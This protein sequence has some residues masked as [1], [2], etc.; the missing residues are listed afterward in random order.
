MLPMVQAKYRGRVCGAPSWAQSGNGNWQVALPFEV[1]Q[2]EHA[3]ETITWIG[4]MHDTADKNG[5][6]GHERVIQSL[7]YAG[8]QGDD[9]SELAELDDGQA[10]QIFT[11]EVELACAPDTYDGKT[12]VKVQ[13]V[14]KVGAGRFAF[15]EA[16]TKNDLKSFAAQMKATVRSAR[17]AV[18]AKKPNGTTPTPAPAAKVSEDDIPF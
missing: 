10:I 13:W 18:I 11:E 9:I 6:T 14:N 7:Q 8:W 17:G 16:A 4:V 5:T 12:R 3:G 15:K 1:T 2:G